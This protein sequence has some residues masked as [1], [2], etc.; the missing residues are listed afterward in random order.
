MID[1]GDATTFN[2]SDADLITSLLRMAILVRLSADG[3]DN[4]HVHRTGI[5]LRLAA[6]LTAAA[7][8]AGHLNLRAAINCIKTGFGIGQKAVCVLS[9]L[10]ETFQ[11]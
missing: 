9:I 8:S 10:I 2:H 4:L 6:R 1:G 7:L 3:S 11:G 5:Y